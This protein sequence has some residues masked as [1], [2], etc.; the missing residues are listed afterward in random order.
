MARIN[1]T[2]PDYVLKETDRRAAKLGTSR[3]SYIA[4]ALNQK[5]QADDLADTLP[6]MNELMKQLKDKLEAVPVVGDGA[7]G[8]SPILDYVSFSGQGQVKQP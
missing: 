7:V 6:Q 1:I 3:S 5:A 2:L 8:R 4:L